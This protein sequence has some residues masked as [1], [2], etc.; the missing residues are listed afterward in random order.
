[1]AKKQSFDKAFEEL[2]QIVD[3]LQ[4]EDSGIDELSS[5]LKKAKALV[6]FCKDKL[7]EVEE[8]IEAIDEEDE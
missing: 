7:R 4:E 5:K 6:G 3:S 2:Q 1:M 8:D